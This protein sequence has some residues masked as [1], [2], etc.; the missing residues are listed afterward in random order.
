MACTLGTSADAN[1]ACSERSA[2]SDQNDA[3]TIAAAEHKTF[4]AVRFDC[5]CGAGEVLMTGP[6]DYVFRG[7]WLD[8]PAS[9]NSAGTPD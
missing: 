5:G 2:T 8:H 9:V 7:N 3:A 6:A 4:C 1:A